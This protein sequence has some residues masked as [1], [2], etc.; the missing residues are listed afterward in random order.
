MTSNDLKTKSIE[1][2][3]PVFK[4]VKTKKIKCGVPSD[5]PTDGRHLIKKAFRLI[6]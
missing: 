4:K 1:K 5:S 2:D 3:E 6:K